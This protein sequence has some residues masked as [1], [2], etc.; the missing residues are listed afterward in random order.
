M[1][2]RGIAS[3]A[4]LAISCALGAGAPAAVA[5]DGGL[6]WSDCG[7]GFQCA[8][9]KVPKDYGRPREGTLDIAEHRIGSLFVNYDG[10]RGARHGPAAR[11]GG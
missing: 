4:T 7:D 9:A 1:A 2:S 5:K 6:R 11:G 3:L 10:Q 8:T